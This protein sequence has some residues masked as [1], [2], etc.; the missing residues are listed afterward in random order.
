MTALVQ[1]VD[2]ELHEETKPVQLNSPQLGISVKAQGK[3]SVAIVTAMLGDETLACEKVDLAKSDA[4]AAFAAQVAQSRDGLSPAAIEKQLM[5]VGA[6][7]LRERSQA[8]GKAQRK[9]SHDLLL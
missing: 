5:Q 7:Q 4:R 2:G 3:G 9:S 8:E 6:D 1:R